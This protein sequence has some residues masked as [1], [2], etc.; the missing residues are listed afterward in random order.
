[1]VVHL[2]LGPLVV[3]VFEHGNEARLAHE[4]TDSLFFR[5]VRLAA[6]ATSHKHKVALRA[7]VVVNFN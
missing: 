2:I 4:T 3:D 7:N 5:A 1:M 6:V